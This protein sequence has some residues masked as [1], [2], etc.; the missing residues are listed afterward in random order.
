MSYHAEL[1]DYTDKLNQAIE[2]I[3]VEDIVDICRSATALI[4]KNE[5]LTLEDQDIVT[6]FAKSHAAAESLVKE[7]RDK[8]VVEAGRSKNARKG[9]KKY[10]GVSNNV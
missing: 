9:I 1:A 3:A 2:A 4:K 5:P 10:K 6:Q 7:V 8:L